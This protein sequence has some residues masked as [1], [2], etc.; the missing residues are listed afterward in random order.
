VARVQRLFC[1]YAWSLRALS[2]VNNKPGRRAASEAWVF[3]KLPLSGRT[4]RFWRW[5]LGPLRGPRVVGGFV[6]VAGVWSA[7][8]LELLSRFPT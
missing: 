2:D 5:A 4:T 6:D 7:A 1:P 8:R 3:C